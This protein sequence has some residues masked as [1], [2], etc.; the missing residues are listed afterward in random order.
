M[1]ARPRFPLRGQTTFIG[2]MQQGGANVCEGFRVS[3]EW[4]R[5][6]EQDHEEV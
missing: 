6:V 2:R 3:D 1:G 4:E 5:A